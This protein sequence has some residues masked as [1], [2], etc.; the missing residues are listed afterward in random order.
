MRWHAQVRRFGGGF[1]GVV[2]GVWAVVV[3]IWWCGVWVCWGWLM[4][5]GEV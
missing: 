1:V 4:G 2:E 3:L 5:G